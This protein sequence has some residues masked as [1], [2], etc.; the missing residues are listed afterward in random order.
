MYVYIY[1]YIYMF[2]EKII[3]DKK[4]KKTQTQKKSNNIHV[5]KI[6]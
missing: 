3:T 5:V 2:Q 4:V 6:I 1:I